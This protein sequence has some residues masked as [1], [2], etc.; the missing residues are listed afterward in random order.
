MRAPRAGARCAVRG[1]L[2]AGETGDGGAAAEEGE[3]PTTG[4]VAAP[5]ED[6]RTRALT[7]ACGHFAKGQTDGVSR[8]A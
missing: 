1:D 2:G 4:W 3:A 7:S 6:A 8:L 5:P